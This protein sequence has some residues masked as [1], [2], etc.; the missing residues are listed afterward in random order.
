MEEIKQKIN[1][2]VSHS[3]SHIISQVYVNAVCNHN[4][5]IGRYATCS[6]DY[7]EA[8][9]LYVQQK[10]IGKRELKCKEFAFDLCGNIT[11]SELLQYKSS[12][13]SL[14]EELRT[15]KNN[16]NKIWS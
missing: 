6:C 16:L 13:E 10:I 8:V 5:M 3:H 1:Q 15:L 4:S 14:V 12:Q 9:C 7:C 2:R 11:L